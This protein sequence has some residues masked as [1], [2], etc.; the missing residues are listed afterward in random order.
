[1]TS[2]LL[3]ISKSIDT[4]VHPTPRVCQIAAMF[5][6]GVSQDRTVQLIPPSTIPIRPGQLIF[7]TG[8]SGG[9]KTTILNLLADQLK[10]LPD[11]HLIAFDA[12]P[13]DCR[14]ALVDA[15]AGSLEEVVQWLSLCGLNDAFVMLR[16]PHEL[17]DGQRYRF[18]LAWTMQQVHSSAASLQV[19][20]ADEF[21][22]TLDRQTAATVARNI[23]KW[24]DRLHAQHKNICFIAAT[25]HDDLLEALAPD[26]LIIAEPGEG[27]SVLE[28]PTTPQC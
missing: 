2:Q 17:S 24:V 8:A 27:L 3:A 21:A 13:M 11:T 20:L 12:A 22:S 26:T 9:G 28:K 14:H 19:V 10:T 6:L 16:K 7:I 1:M 18:R 4:A 25:T 23:R 5:G 15:L